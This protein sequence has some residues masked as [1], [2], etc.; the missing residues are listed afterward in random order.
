MLP[1]RGYT[2]D[3]RN[4]SDEDIR[5]LGHTT[6]PIL[7]LV[8]LTD[9]R[10]LTSVITAWYPTAS[11][12]ER[13]LIAEHPNTPPTILADLCHGATALSHVAIRHPQCPLD[14]LTHWA[15]A[16][17]TTQREA[18]AR[19]PACPDM[20]LAQLAQDP[21]AAVVDTAARHAHLPLSAFHHLA[22][23]PAYHLSLALN[24]SAPIDVLDTIVTHLSHDPQYQIAR[25]VAVHPSVSTAQL[26]RLADLSLPRH[27]HDQ[28]WIFIA[29]HPQ[30]DPAL[31][32]RFTRVTRNPEI[33]LALS[34]APAM[35]GDALAF[36]A[37]VS[38]SPTVH[39]NILTHPH[40]LPATR[41]ALALKTNP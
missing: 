23:I 26:S 19:N 35:P 37:K 3:P 10:T 40:T 34:L 16:S 2:V 6:S 21:Q 38:T 12:E 13:Y 14:I 25:T 17:A 32:L 4:L 39:Q 11:N 29:A 22:R 27:E 30:A 7:R 41:V 33:R 20:L 9:P 15:T 8:A 31:L 1:F 18:A 24:P 28:L 36:L 5:L